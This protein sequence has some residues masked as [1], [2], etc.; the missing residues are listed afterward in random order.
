LGTIHRDVLGYADYNAD[1]S[2]PSLVSALVA[3]LRSA[4]VTSLRYA[5]GT[6]G[7]G[8]DLHSWRGGDDC[9]HIPGA[10][11]AARNNATRNTLD[12]YI[13]QIAQ[14]LGLHIGYT[15]NYGT[16]P[17]ACNAGGDPIVNGGDLVQ[18]ANLT[19]HY[20]IKYWE[21]G[22]EQY[23][24]STEADFHSNPNNGGSYAQYESGFYDAMKGKDA[25]IVIG[26]P[27]GLTYYAAQVNFDFPVLASA[28]Y[29]AVVYHN[30]PM[31]DP[32]SDGSTLY[33]ERV[34]ANVRRIR[35]ALL[36]LQTE[37]LNNGKEPDLIW[38]TEWDGNVSGN[39]WSKQTMGAVM[40]LFVAAQLAEYMQAGVQYATWWAQ[41]ETDV[42]SRYNYDENGDGA[43]N[44]WECGSGFLVYTGPV[45]GHGEV[46]VGLKRG[47]L[48]P[49]ARAFQILSQSGF[50]SEG[51]HM[52]RTEADVQNA[53]WL[54]SY[55]ATHGSSYAVILINRDRDS[56]HV[57]PVMLANMTSGRSAQQWTYGRT[58]YDKSRF[59]DWSAGPVR[60][61]IGAWSS[62]YRATLPPWSVNVI[63]FE[64]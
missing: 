1:L 51:E 4:G 54:L 22:N 59:G 62:I 15:V 45:V 39:K 3:G 27:I 63:V 32:I 19:K 13:P 48:T 6:G 57:V 40:P 49:S 35:G 24:R 42:C 41:G 28:K 23:S 5:S 56:A 29:D 9:T 18:Y 34:T 17:P 46:P 16:N 14:P 7:I 44:W 43:Y 10:T 33:Q 8:A 20:G 52:L 47:D 55:A 38:I 12:T 31:I 53:P 64:R 61:V 25:S 11:A 37:L 58:Q 21:I 60:T 26:V 2:N 50:V 36:T 30:Y